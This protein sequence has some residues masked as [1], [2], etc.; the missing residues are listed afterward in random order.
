MT[1][2][3]AKASNE[4]EISLM[5]ESLGTLMRASLSQTNKTFSIR[6]ELEFLIHILQ[7]N[8]CVLKNS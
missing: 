1:N 4:H 2:W 8:S 6:Q 7:F 5:V 3:R